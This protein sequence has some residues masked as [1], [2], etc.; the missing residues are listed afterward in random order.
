MRYRVSDF[1]ILPFWMAS[2]HMHFA[3]SRDA[4]HAKERV[5]PKSCCCCCSARKIAIASNTHASLDILRD[6]LPPNTQIRRVSTPL[7]FSTRLSVCRIAVGDMPWARANR[8][9]PFGVRRII[10]YCAGCFCTPC[11]SPC[12]SQ[13]TLG[14]LDVLQ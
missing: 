3:C 13:R 8:P 9:T 1:E 11:T 2:H 6:V 12:R 10:C 14:I 5:G 7:S 4:I